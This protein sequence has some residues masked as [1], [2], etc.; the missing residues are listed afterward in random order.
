[1]DECHDAA[2]HF[3]CLGEPLTGPVPTTLTAARAPAT[4]PGERV[5][6]ARIA[7]TV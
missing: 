6:G 3:Q 4:Q 1:M 7:V 5:P 2:L